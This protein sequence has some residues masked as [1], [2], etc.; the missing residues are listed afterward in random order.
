M[1][2]Q[3]RSSSKWSVAILNSLLCLLGVDDLI[4]H[5]IPFGIV[6]LAGG[7]VGL[8]ALLRNRRVAW[9]TRIVLLILF[10]IAGVAEI[11]MGRWVWGLFIL[12]LAVLVILVGY[13]E[14][15]KPIGVS[16]TERGGS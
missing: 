10:A 9:G 6:L 15:R 16:Q 4:R 7:G 12:I 13:E 5:D 1:Q 2:D 8:V 14:R 3:S 11:A